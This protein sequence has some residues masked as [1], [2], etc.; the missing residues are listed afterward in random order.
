MSPAIAVFGAWILFGASHLML[1][2]P[3]LRDPLADRFG[4]YRFLAIYTLITTVS[5]S[6]L[7]AAVARYGG[8]GLGGPN[9]A[10]VTTARWTLGGIAALGALLATAG[11]V[12]YRRSP[13]AVLARR[14]RAS[15]EAKAKPL[16]ARGAIERVTRHPFF[17]GLAVL[18]SAHALLAST[19]AAAIFFGGFVVFVV[20]GVLM[21]DRKLLKRHGNVYGAYQS[22]S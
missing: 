1:S 8:D 15:N 18:M 16:P 5:L 22:E 20:I 3:R 21:Q 9:L 13:M 12:N 11:I 19:L 2:A 6:L 17:V 10:T 4:Q 7:I 14:W